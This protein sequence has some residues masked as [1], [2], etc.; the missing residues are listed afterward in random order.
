MQQKIKFFFFIKIST[1]ILLSWIYHLTVM[2]FDKSNLYKYSDQKHN[3]YRQLDTRIYRIVSEDKKIKHSNNGI[4]KEKNISNNK[5]ETIQYNK[6]PCKRSL[7]NGRDIEHAKNNK[8]IED[9]KGNIY[10]NKR[11][12]NKNYYLRNVRK[13]ANADFKFLRES[14]QMK[15]DW[16][17]YLLFLHLISIPATFI[18]I[19]DINICKEWWYLPAFALICILQF[20]VIVVASYIYRKTVKCEKL[21]HIKSDMHNTAYPSLS[22]LLF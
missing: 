12:F 5:K 4:Y 21:R 17:F 6:Q 14:I 3:V 15:D 22:K 20:V 1:F 18:F 16:F 9:S 7:K 19:F 2:R 13:F 11:I 8:F 10:F